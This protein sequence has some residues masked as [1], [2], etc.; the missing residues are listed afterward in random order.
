MRHSPALGKRDGTMPC[1]PSR[2]QQSDILSVEGRPAERPLG[3]VWAQ[4]L[5]GVTG[6]IGRFQGCRQ[7]PGWAAWLV[8]RSCDFEACFHSLGL[9]PR[10][11][12]PAVLFGQHS[13]S[14][15]ALLK[16]RGPLRISPCLL[17]VA[18]LGVMVWVLCTCSPLTL[19]D[20]RVKSPS[21]AVPPPYFLRFL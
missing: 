8:A 17:C 20:R 16:T 3:R 18:A 9:D 11:H 1:C 12:R 14:L 21:P 15:E 5:S 2:R 10:E 4:L 19:P 6:D 7:L 13:S